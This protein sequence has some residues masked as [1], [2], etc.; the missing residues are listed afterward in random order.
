MSA[1]HGDEPRQPAPRER[2]AGTGPSA[3]PPANP[4]RGEARP[5]HPERRD[6]PPMH[7]ERGLGPVSVVVVNY[8]GERYLDACLSAV[9][10]L[11]G[12]LAEV[13][14]VDNAST[15]AS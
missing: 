15:D 12:E 2:P 7:A 11:R 5:A 9:A 14:V 8:N 4:S 6:A 1:Q 13:I 3:A 10:A